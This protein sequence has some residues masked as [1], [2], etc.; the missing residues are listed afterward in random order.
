MEDSIKFRTNDLELR[1][2]KIQMFVGLLDKDLAYVGTDNAVG[3]DFFKDALPLDLYNYWQSKGDES[4]YVLVTKVVYVIDQDVTM[5]NEALLSDEQML[6]S[7]MPDYK[8]EK[9]G[10][11]KFHMDC[12]FMAPSFDYELNFYK[13]PYK[14]NI[15]SVQESLQKLNP[16]LGE[17]TLSVVQ[18]NY[19]YGR[20]LMHK[21]SKM[22]VCIANYYPFDDGKT[23]EVN[24]TLNYIHELPPSLLGG[25]KLLIKEIKEGI[26]SLVF[27]TRSILSATGE[28]IVSSQ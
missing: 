4:Y 5:F 3:F 22:S 8:I 24:Y 18:H 23:L 12:G 21:T 26:S 6:K 20:V 15:A 1:A 10:K 28:P 16:E 11:N 14:S 17:P 13:P 2:N 27:N 25:H 19:K 9:I 7:K